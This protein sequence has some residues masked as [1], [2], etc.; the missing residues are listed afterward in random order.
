MERSRPPELTGTLECETGPVSVQVLKASPHTLFVRFPEGNP[1]AHR[2]EL[3]NFVLRVGDREFALGRSRY[4]SH[5]E[6]PA[7]RKDDPPLL[8]DGKLAFLDDLY[9]FQV[10]MRTGTIQGFKKR[11]EQLP[12]LWGRKKDIRPAFREFVAELVYDLQVY[13]SLLDEVD[14]SLQEEPWAI[15]TDVHRVV[16]Q[17]EYPGFCALF[18]ERL[19]R[20]AEQVKDFSQ[21]EHE[22][23]GFYL[24][25][26][27][28]DIIRSSEFLLR[29]NLKPRG[30]A[31]DSMMMRMLYEND[32]RGPTAFARFM[33]KHPVE[34]AAAQAVR[35]RVGLLSERIR[36]LPRTRGRRTR[37]MSVAAGPAWELR[38]VFQRPEDLEAYEVV[39]LDQDREAL[40]EATQ[41]IQ[42][43]EKQL[44]GRMH[45]TLIQDSVRTM[46]RTPDL[47]GKWGRFSFVYSMGLFDY[48][49][50]P[51]ARVVLA[52]L[53][54]LLE[55]G[56]ELVVGNFHVDSPTRLYMEYWM[57][58]VL[59]YR[60]EAEFLELSDGLKG[61]QTSVFFEDTRCQMFLSVRKAGE[62]TS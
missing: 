41:M 1:P 20:L 42:R 9:D 6:N 34:T 57:D 56:G 15:R 33:H 31:G 18:D 19:A 50:A 53:Y 52:R 10:L 23:H 4:H 54:D 51:V 43:L 62:T 45:Y 27:A 12:A 16:T 40:N 14:R 30:Y 49:T 5:A 29:T 46:L 28:W 35:N 60:T 61:A 48:L 13:R 8:G 26:H 39:L 24:R 38:E 36:A 11:L 47:P 25:K 21:E 55:P 32:F 3:R 17:S 37:F 22:R 2:A 44:G 58:W 7:R 59:I